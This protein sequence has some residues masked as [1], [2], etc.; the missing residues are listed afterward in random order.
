[1]VPLS[2]LP[3]KWGNWDSE[4]WNAKLLKGR[5]DFDPRLSKSWVHMAWYLIIVWIQVSQLLVTT[6]NTPKDFFL[7]WISY[8][9]IFLSMANISKCKGSE[10]AKGQRR[11]E[12]WGFRANVLA[13]GRTGFGIKANWN[14]EDT[15]HSY[16]RACAACLCSEAGMGVPQASRPDVGQRESKTRVELLASK[17]LRKLLKNYLYFCVWRQGS[18]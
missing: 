18:C 16:C 8:F 12:R 10:E 17:Q 11:L 1:M 6:N 5:G 9:L 13:M 3:Y 14:Q 2:S 7:G 15:L 4:S